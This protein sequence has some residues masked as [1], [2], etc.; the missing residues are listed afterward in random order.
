M[1]ATENYFEKLT[2]E[3]LASIKSALQ[4]IPRDTPNRRQTIA[5]QVDMEVKDLPAFV[6]YDGFEDALREVKEG[7]PNR[8]HVVAQKMQLE[9]AEIPAL[10]R[11]IRRDKLGL[12]VRS[13]YQQKLD[14]PRNIV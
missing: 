2:Q 5:K 7:T 3:K 10:E 11:K 6:K 13:N 4:D 9:E 8:S 1:V 14:R 12:P